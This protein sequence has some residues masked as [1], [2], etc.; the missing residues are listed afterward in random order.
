MEIL[1]K[2]DDTGKSSIS[3]KELLSLIDFSSILD[4]ISKL[5][6]KIEEISNRPIIDRETIIKL[7]STDVINL[8]EPTNFSCSSSIE[9][10]ENIPDGVFYYD[11]VNNRF[12][13]KVNNL[14]KTFNFE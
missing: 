2:R 10:L 8:N 3:E 4:L 7:L 1:L 12:R 9:K 14:W 11:T 13:G 6:S 5:E